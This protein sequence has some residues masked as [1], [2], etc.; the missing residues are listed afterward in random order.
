MPRCYSKKV[1]AKLNF[2]TGIIYLNNYLS[3]I[4]HFY[5]VIQQ[6]QIMHGISTV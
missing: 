2:A 1:L 5:L 6:K 3:S 4:L